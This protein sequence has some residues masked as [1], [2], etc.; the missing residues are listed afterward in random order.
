M[1]FSEGRGGKRR[2]VATQPPHSRLGV[3]DAT[4]GVA[5]GRKR[6]QFRLE[7]RHEAAAS[8]LS[9]HGPVESPV[10]VRSFERL[11]VSRRPPDSSASRATWSARGAATPR[12]VVAHDDEQRSVEIGRARMP[13]LSVYERRPDATG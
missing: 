8:F 5:V 11:R 3:A 6:A 12:A 7:A 9:V 13:A 4:A 1:K 10:C 2:R